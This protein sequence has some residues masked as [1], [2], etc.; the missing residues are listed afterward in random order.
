[1]GSVLVVFVLVKHTLLRNCVKKGIMRKVAKVG[2]KEPC[3]DPAFLGE[4]SR[5][6]L[7][8]FDRRLTP[9]KTNQPLLQRA[10]PC[11]RNE[12]FDH[13]HHGTSK[14]AF[15]RFWVYNV[16]SLKASMETL[17][18]SVHISLLNTMCYTMCM[19]MYVQKWQRTVELSQVFEQSLLSN[20]QCTPVVHNL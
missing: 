18:P 1:M 17:R 2:R 6:C 15:Q 12:Y 5:W 9:E 8:V 4:C 20:C 16:D 11:P 7:T 19:C 14:R 13:N 10:P 3:D